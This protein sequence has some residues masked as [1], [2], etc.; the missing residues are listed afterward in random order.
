MVAFVGVLLQRCTTKATTLNQQFQ[1]VYTI[2]DASNIPDIGRS[3]FPIMPG[4]G[5]QATA[6]T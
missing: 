2:E 1:S 6:W 4:R 3:Q 5:F